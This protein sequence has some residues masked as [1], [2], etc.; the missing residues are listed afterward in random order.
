M[1]FPTAFTFV[2][3]ERPE[4]L[5]MEA[6]RPPTLNGVVGQDET[7]ARLRAFADGLKVHRVVPPHLLLVGP[8]G[9]GKTTAARAYAFEILGED[10]RA[11]FHQLNAS[12]DRS[13]PLVAHRI[14]PLALSPPSR[15]AS[16]RIVFFDE[17]DQLR[18]DVQAALRPALEAAAGTTQF[19]LAC[20]DSAGID[21]P[22][23]SRCAVLRFGLVHEAGIRRCLIDA[24]VRSGRRVPDSLIDEIATRANGNPR[25]AVKQLVEGLARLARDRSPG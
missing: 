6:L 5:T 13:F 16:L 19:I 8:P 25:E 17:A 3:A 9:V 7:V 10:W 11:S 21:P 23:R 22:L 14:V 12:D 24:A 1:W 15:G 2:A 18:N 20:N 4:R